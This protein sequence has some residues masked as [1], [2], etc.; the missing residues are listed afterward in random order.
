M[1]VLK[2]VLATVIMFSLCCFVVSALASPSVELFLQLGHGAS[3][4]SVVFSP[5]GKLLAS[6]SQDY[7]VKLWIVSE[8]K[9]LHTFSG[10]G[11][12]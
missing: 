9:L 8:G 1:S 10:H 12:V 3:V 5:D 7:T 6:G 2:N 11:G 4:T